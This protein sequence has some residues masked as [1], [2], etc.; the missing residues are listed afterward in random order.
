MKEAEKAALRELSDEKL[1]SAARLTFDD[2]SDMMAEFE[3]R[4]FEPRV[5]KRPVKIGGSLDFR[6]MVE[7]LL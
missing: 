5:D 3:R 2:L 4:G 1:A 7:M 6:K